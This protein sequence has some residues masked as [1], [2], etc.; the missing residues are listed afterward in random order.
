MAMILSLDSIDQ[1]RSSLLVHGRSENT[2]RGYT[3]DLRM[4]LTWTGTKEVTTAN[5]EIRGM[6]WLNAFRSEVSPKTTGRRLSSLRAY[7]TWLGMDRPLRHYKPPTPSRPIPHP[8]PEGM[9]GV[10]KMADLARTTEQRALVALCG[11]VGCRIAE[12]LS[13]RTRDFD[14]HEMTLTIRGKGDKT[15]VVP[16]S[17]A[18]WT[19]ISSRYVEA[20]QVVEGDRRLVTYSDRGARRFLTTVAKKAGCRRTVSSHD[21]RATLATAAYDSTKDL[22]AV[23]E[24]LGH[25]TSATTE[26]YTGVTMSKMREAVE[27]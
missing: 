21:L 17:S 8:I 19:A 23:Q 18:A 13:I 25:A 20:L 12:A 16:V 1:M 2:V 11:M 26:I 3:T 9:E 27:V 15:R 4:F 22:R 10:Q 6:E 14:L 7:G 5:L 24:I